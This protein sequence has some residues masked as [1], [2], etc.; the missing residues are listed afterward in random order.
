MPI[1]LSCLLVLPQTSG[2]CLAKQICLADV[3]S[4]KY[5]FQSVSVDSPNLHE[6]RC[7]KLLAMQW[8]KTFFDESEDEDA[9]KL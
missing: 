5:Y 2:F 3:R 8:H 7:R 1:G 6:K 9:S 4:T